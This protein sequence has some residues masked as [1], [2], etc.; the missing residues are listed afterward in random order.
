MKKSPPDTMG[1]LVTR[2][3]KY[4]RLDDVSRIKREQDSH[5]EKKRLTKR[6]IGEGSEKRAKRDG[7]RRE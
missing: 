7:R 5:F 2:A 3:N 6:R 4:I 1:K